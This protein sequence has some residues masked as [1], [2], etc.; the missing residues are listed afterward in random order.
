MSQSHQ[1]KLSDT[2]GVFGGRRR[3]PVTFFRTKN[4][5]S[6]CSRFP[7]RVKCQD[8]PNILMEHVNDAVIV[9]Q[10]T[11]VNT[12]KFSSLGPERQISL[13]HRRIRQVHI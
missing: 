13:V 4:Y 3:A 8:R 11:L 9:N 6:D 5:G 10:G 7:G 12:S 2:L 1:K